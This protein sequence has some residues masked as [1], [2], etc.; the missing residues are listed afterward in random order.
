MPFLQAVKHTL[1]TLGKAEPDRSSQ[2]AP[3]QLLECKHILK[4]LQWS[5]G[6]VLLR[7][8]VLIML[9]LLEPRPADSRQ[10]TACN[11]TCTAHMRGHRAFACQVPKIQ[12]RNR[13][14]E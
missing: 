7:E 14:S 9:A 6:C 1:A 3:R 5:L 12:T 11:T 4:Q 13:L 8:A 2:N 10:P